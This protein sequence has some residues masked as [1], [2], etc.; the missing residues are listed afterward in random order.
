MIEYPSSKVPLESTVPKEETK[1]P[2]DSKSGEKFSY[3]DE[4]IRNRKDIDS[5]KQDLASE[6]LNTITIFGI[7]AALLTFLGA[8]IQVFKYIEDFWIFIGL[9]A[10]LVSSMLL[11]VLSLQSIIHDKYTWKKF[12]SSPIIWIIFCFLILSIGAFLIGS[13]GFVQIQIQG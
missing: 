13:G 11:F 1:Q 3:E 7:F 9:S 8:E 12:F 10:F 5:I 6:R 4:T 2:L